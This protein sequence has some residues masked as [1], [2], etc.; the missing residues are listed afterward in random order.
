MRLVLAAS[1]VESACHAAL[2]DGMCRQRNR[3]L[4]GFLPH[5]MDEE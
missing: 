1:A 5:D 4:A 2:T 3:E